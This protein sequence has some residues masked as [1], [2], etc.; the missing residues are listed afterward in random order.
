MA[1][2]I[3]NLTTLILSK[4]IDRYLITLKYYIFISIYT[5]NILYY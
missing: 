5:V 3:V 1:S 2:Y 4:L